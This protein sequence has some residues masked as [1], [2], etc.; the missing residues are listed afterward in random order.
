MKKPLDP[1]FE[2]H[3]LEK[4][5][6]NYLFISKPMPPDETKAKSKRELYAEIKDLDT[7]ESLLFPYQKP[8]SKF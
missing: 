1:L 2:K 7:T 3:Q 5:P 4:L 6:F 8:V